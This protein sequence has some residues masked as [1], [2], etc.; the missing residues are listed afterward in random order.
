MG[1]LVRDRIP[2]LIRA[3]GA[4]PV[5]RVLDEAEYDTALRDKLVEEAQELR[6]ASSSGEL[7]AEAADVYEVLAALADRLGV[8][9]GTIAQAAQHK[10]AERGAFEERIWLESY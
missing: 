10:R 5:T 9:L 2:E 1:K 7:L 4:E 8:D 6:N 3:R